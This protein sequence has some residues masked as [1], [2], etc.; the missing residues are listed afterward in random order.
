MGDADGDEGWLG[1]IGGAKLLRISHFG[2]CGFGVVN[3]EG[4]DEFAGGNRDQNGR[5]GDEARLG[6]FGFFAGE[7]RRGRARLDP[8]RDGFRALW[9]ILKYNLLR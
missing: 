9:A 4:R 7:A 8:G 1:V 5:L 2:V 3:P 6:R